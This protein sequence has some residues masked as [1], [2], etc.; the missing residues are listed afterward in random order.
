VLRDNYEPYIPADELVRQH[1]REHNGTIDDY[2]IKWDGHP[3]A[4]QNTL[5]AD[6]MKKVVLDAI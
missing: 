2:Y 1:L 4:L 5:L 3:S 6:V